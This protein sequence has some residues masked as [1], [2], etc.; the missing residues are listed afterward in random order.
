MEE[1]DPREL[2]TQSEILE[3]ELNLEG[4]SLTRLCTEL[5]RVAANPRLWL[6]LLAATLV[7][8][9]PV[10]AATIS[11][12][13]TFSNGAVADA[14]EVNANFGVLIGE[15]NDQ[16]FRIGAL[17]NE[18]ALG[19]SGE[20]CYLNDSC[21]AG[22]SCNVGLGICEGVPPQ[23]GSSGAACYPNNT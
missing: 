21:D 4:G 12:P 18:V 8:S 5:A 9:I 14:N 19:G 3:R 20:P 7:I 15:S 6:A 23:E 17:E 11:A 13:Y 16:D 10:Y 2:Q 22:L 1:V